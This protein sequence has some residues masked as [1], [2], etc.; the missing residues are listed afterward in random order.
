VQTPHPS[1]EKNHMR[2]VQPTVYRVP[3]V[4]CDL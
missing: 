4:E 3:S 2:S 1:L